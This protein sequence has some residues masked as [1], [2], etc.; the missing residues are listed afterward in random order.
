MAGWHKANPQNVS[1]LE[2]D[3]VAYMF[4]T[5]ANLPADPQNIVAM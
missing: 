2:S 4:Y 3:R 1:S 5:I